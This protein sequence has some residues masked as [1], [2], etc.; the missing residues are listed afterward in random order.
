M[1]ARPT[2]S[3]VVG[4]A[5][6]FTL[7]ICVPL[8]A[9]N[10]LSDKDVEQLMNNT[11]QDAKRFQSAFNQ[12]VSKSVIRKTSQ[13]KDAKNLVDEFQKSTKALKEHFKQTKKS[14]PY[15]QNTLDSARQIEKT[16][17]DVQLSP[18]STT[19]WA[20]VRKE[21]DDLAAA[22]NLSASTNN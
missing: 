5:L 10:R 11:Y 14:D 7:V 15:L 16:L 12:S 2:F 22:F 17:H 8:L 21:L 13:E 20:K 9:Q 6:I 4:A 18:E 1:T 3:L 19:Q